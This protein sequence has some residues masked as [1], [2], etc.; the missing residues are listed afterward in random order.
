MADL[1]K[2]D[3]VYMCNIVLS[4]YYSAPFKVAVWR[5]TASPLLSKIMFFA[6]ALYVVFV[7]LLILVN[8]CW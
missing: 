4:S 7:Y 1:R 3:V 8:L 6:L 2:T 5:I